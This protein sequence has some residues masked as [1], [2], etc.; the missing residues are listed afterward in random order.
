[1]IY[2]PNR[3]PHPGSRVNE[4]VVGVLTAS[5][6]VLAGVITLAQFANY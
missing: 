5:I 6:L 2:V 1:M 3:M 4:I